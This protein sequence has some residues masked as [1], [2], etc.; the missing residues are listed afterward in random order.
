M[1]KG[2]AKFALV[3][4]QIGL[5]LGNYWYTFGLWP[6]SWT[7]F[8]FYAVGMIVVAALNVMIDAEAKS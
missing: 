8:I 2:I 3:V 4:I 6:K 1:T 5:M 7:S